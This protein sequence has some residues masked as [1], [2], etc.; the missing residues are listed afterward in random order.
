VQDDGFTC[1]K[2]LPAIMQT[3]IQSNHAFFGKQKLFQTLNSSDKYCLWHRGSHG[4][5][6]HTP[7]ITVHI[8]SSKISTNLATLSSN[9]KEEIV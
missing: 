4:H 1:D 8:S 3:L 5:D 7:F 2:T 9:K 6:P